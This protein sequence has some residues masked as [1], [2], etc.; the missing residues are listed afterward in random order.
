[1]LLRSVVIALLWVVAATAQANEQARVIATLFSDAPPMLPVSVD[2]YDDSELNLQLRDDV[3]AALKARGV[4]VD[5]AGALLLMLDLQVR[6]GQMERT[7]PSLGQAQTSRG[8]A[9]V[10][11][12][13][14]S[15]TEDSLLGGQR[16]EPG[17]RILREGLVT[18]SGQLRDQAENEVVWQGDASTSMDERGLEGLAPLLVDPLADSYGRT[19]D[20]EVTLRR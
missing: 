9:Q 20:R 7:D 11:V 6:Q 15:N 2:V 19:E 18:L 14:L 12:N 13:V 1:M 10:D 4:T 17:V 16:S 3:I 8:G 5:P